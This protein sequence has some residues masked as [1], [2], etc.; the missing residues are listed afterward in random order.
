MN[1]PRD[2]VLPFF[3]LVW[4]DLFI[5]TTGPVCQL[6]HGK[7]LALVAIQCFEW[8]SLEKVS[9]EEAAYCQSRILWVEQRMVLK[10]VAS[11]LISL[12]PLFHCF[13][14]CDF[15]SLLIRYYLIN[16]DLL[17]AYLVVWRTRLVGDV[18]S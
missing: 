1:C 5:D 16:L 13:L 7:E 3:L 2:Q 9:H 4:Q 11:L 6:L 18:L 17:W 12:E 15:I 10:I 8:D 14:P